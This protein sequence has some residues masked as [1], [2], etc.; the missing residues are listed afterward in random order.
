MADKALIVVDV[1]ND[2]CPGGALGVAGGDE[3]VPMINGLIGRF[4]HVVLTQD[5][6]PAGHSSFASSHPGK[7]PFEM[8]AMPYGAQ[9]LWPDHCVQGSAGA[10]FHPALEWTRAELLIRKGFRPQIDSYSAFFEN[11][12]RTPTGLSGYLRDRGIK[13]V[14]LCGLATDFCVAFS[15]LDAVAQGFSTTVVLDACRGIDLNGSLHAMV[16]RMRDAGVELN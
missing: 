15:A 8:I 1:Q 3:I 14:T 5:W 10:N 7:N 11:D 4:E 12:R 16:T 13:K 6:H 9:T 2:F